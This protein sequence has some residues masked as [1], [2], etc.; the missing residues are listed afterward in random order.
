MFKKRKK[1][2][3]YRLGGIKHEIKHWLNII[4]SR[5]AQQKN[6]VV[7]CKLTGG[8]YTHGNTET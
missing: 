6:G 8:K 5:L 1:D 2:N 3:N 4:N 7:N